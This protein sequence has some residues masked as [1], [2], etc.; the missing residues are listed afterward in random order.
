MNRISRMKDLR[1][2]KG[3]DV[4]V[5]VEVLK[6]RGGYPEDLVK[7]LEDLIGDMLEDRY[8]TVVINPEM[9]QPRSAA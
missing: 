8:H 7:E 5:T 1:L 4:I 6:Y 9:L 2:A 3:A